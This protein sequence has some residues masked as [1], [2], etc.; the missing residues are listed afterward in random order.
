MS[1]AQRVAIVGGGAAGALAAVHLLREPRE[2]GA[3][4]IEL[5][6]RTGAFGAGVAYGTEDPLHLLNVPAVRMGGIAG[7]PEHFHEWLAE[8]SEPVTEAAFLPRGLYATYVRDLLT[9]AERDAVDARLRRRAGEVV[10]LAEQGGD[11]VSPLELTFADGERLEVDRVVLALGPL[12]AGDPIRVPPELKDSGVYVADPWAT[13]ALEEARRDRAVLIVGTGLSMVDVAL[14]LGDGEQGPRVRAVSRHGLVPRRHRRDLTNLRRFHIP[15]ESGG[16]DPVVGAIFGQICRVS[17]QGDDWR[18]VIDSMR[19]A[20]PR[21]WK[22]LRVEEKRRFLAEFQRLWD[23]HRFRMAPAVADRFD[24]LRAAGR[25]EIGA[26]AIVSLEPQGARARVFL[27]TPGSHDLDTAE[28]D[29]VINCSGAGCDLRRQ[30][31]PLLAGLLAAGSA[32]ADELGLGLDV[33][34]DGA[35]L[36]AAGVASERLFAVGALRKGV[37]WEAI[38]ITEIRDHSGAV[39]RRIVAAGEREEEPSTPTELRARLAAAP[40]EWEAA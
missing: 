28:V 23:V 15:I 30:A 3:L 39:A 9:C 8:R 21:L 31:P 40:T 22:G 16:I 13:G 35:L 10:A 32:R 7:H 38:G 14:S 33:A 24:A 20:T 12:G 25:L 34:E 1:A 26:N 27:R 5:I 6:D 36:D 37:E 19:P 11:P 29:R 4:E 17:Q 2:R 18:D